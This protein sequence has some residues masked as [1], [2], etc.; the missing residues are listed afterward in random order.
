MKLTVIGLSITSSWGNGHAT[1]FR[2]LLKAY[3]KLG[4]DITFL[5]R[6]V[7]YYEKNRDLSN[8]D[9]CE[10]KLYNSNEELK[11]L[12]AKDITN[13]DVVM[14]GSYV[15]E[16]IEVAEIIFS[17]AK[18]VTVF[19]DIDT[20]VTLRKLTMGNCPYL[21]PSQIARFD[22]Y[23][24][25]SGGPILDFIMDKYH[26]PCARALY[27]SVDVE[28]Y[29]PIECSEQWQLGYLGT[30]S[31]DRQPTVEELLNY[32]AKWLPE[33]QF[34]V[35]GP[36]YPKGYPWASNVQR[37]AHLPPSQHRSFYNSQRYTLNVTRRDMIDAGYSPSVRL[38]EAAACGVPIISDFWN[39]IDTFFEIQDEILI[40]QSCK[41][42]L[43][44]WNEI[45]ESERLSIGKRARNK[46]LKYHSS[47]IRAKELEYYVME[48]LSTS[49][50]V[51]SLDIKEQ[52]E[53]L[54]S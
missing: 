46:V 54:S 33:K 21:S 20:P 35:A 19:Y 12:H 53:K 14:L 22:L 29:Y 34:V 52:I 2:S 16:G 8:P 47:T 5:E 17:L 42:V 1:T 11:T 4:H 51:M 18:G 25:F 48:V 38:F 45:S 31:V 41:N 9:F 30:H 7:E 15:M 39:G 49:V 23:L 24:S 44:L 37:I 13:A 50:K 36:Q 10:I 27:C 28:L 3:K 6:D 43:D 40:A 32:P 26:A